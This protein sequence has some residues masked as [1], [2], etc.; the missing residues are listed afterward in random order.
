MITLDVLCSFQLGDVFTLS[1]SLTQFKML[2]LMVFH[3][4]IA[5]RPYQQGFAT[6][7]SSK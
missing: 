2:H 1:L 7:A 4:D 6:R 3:I 5:A